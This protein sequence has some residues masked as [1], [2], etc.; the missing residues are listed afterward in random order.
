M[1]LVSPQSNDFLNTAQVLRA[2]DSAE[3]NGATAEEIEALK[4]YAISLGFQLL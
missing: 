3:A 1:L 4:Q 2:L